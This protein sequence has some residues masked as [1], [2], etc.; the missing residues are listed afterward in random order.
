[1]ARTLQGLFD[2]NCFMAVAMAMAMATKPHGLTATARWQL[3]NGNGTTETDW[4][5]WKL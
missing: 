4:L 1:M 5:Q 3:L 2:G